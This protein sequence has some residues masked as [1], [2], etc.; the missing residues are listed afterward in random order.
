MEYDVV[1]GGCEKENHESYRVM[2]KAGMIQKNFYK[3][4]DSIFY[5]D[6]EAYAH[7]LTSS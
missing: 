5:I 6:K 4:G 1:Y 7:H 2:Q 3:N